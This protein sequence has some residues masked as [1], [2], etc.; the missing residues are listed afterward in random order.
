MPLET[1]CEISQKATALMCACSQNERVILNRARFIPLYLTGQTCH[2]QGLLISVEM[3]DRQMGVADVN[4]KPA[5]QSKSN[6][7][8]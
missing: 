2:R 8:S 7:L 5:H 6:V 3:Y 4:D 1:L